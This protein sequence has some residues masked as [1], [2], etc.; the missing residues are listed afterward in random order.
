M[1]MKDSEM[2]ILETNTLP[3]LTRNSLLPKAFCAA[4]GTY[5]G[6]LDEMINSALAK[7]STVVA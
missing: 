7:R 1:I 6:L 4:G 5:S 3:G 2:Y